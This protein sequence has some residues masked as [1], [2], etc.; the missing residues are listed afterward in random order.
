MMLS[1]QMHYDY[2]HKTAFGTQGKLGTFR[3]AI[4]LTS[5]PTTFQPT[6]I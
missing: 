3:N 4:R 6:I 2:V 1:D 5:A